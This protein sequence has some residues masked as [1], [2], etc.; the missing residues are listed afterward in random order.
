LWRCW[1]FFGGIPASIIRLEVCKSASFCACIAFC[2][3]TERRKA[4]KAGIA[5]SSRPVGTVDTGNCTDSVL[6][7]PLSISKQNAIYTQTP[8]P[9]HF[10]PEDGGGMYLRNIDNIVPQNMV[11]QVKNRMNL[12]LTSVKIRIGDILHFG[13]FQKSLM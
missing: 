9:T 3:E 13:L 5:A 2:L 6:P 1:G 12:K 4:G 10:D 7:F 8:K 11:P